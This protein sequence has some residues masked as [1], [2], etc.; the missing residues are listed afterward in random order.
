LK[1][2]YYLRTLAAT[3][4]EK[5]TGRGGE[6][7]AVPVSGGMAATGMGAMSATGGTS[8]AFGASSYAGDGAAESA[9][10]CAI[11]DPECEA[12]Q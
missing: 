5:S 3:S 11:D 8:N 6:L 1:T 12:C 4:A 10:F 9:K 2:T 7:N